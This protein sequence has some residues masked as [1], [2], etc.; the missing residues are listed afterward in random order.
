MFRN[1]SILLI[2]IICFF[3]CGK[4]QQNKEKKKEISF[5]P[6]VTSKGVNPIV[7]LSINCPPPP[8]F[9][10]PEKDSNIKSGQP[11]ENSKRA[12]IPPPIT[13]PILSEEAGGLPFIQTF[14]TE[15]GLGLSTISCGN[16]DHNGNLWFGTQ[17]GGVSKYD[18]KSFTNYTTAQGL[19][20]NI[21][22]CILEDKMGNLWFGTNGGGVSRYDGKSFTSYTTEHGLA[23]NIVLSIT[24]DNNGSLW[25]STT[26]GISKQ[27][28]TIKEKSNSSSPPEERVHFT[29][30]TI[31]QGL[32]GNSVLTSLADTKGNIWFGTDKG[33][34]KFNPNINEKTG[35][36]CFSNFTTAQGLSNNHVLDI[37]EDKSGN[38]WFGT[39][40]GGVSKYNP[41]SK[42]RPGDSAFLNYSFVHDN[43]LNYVYCITEDHIGNLWFGTASGVCKYDPTISHEKGALPMTYFNTAQGLPNEGIRSITE[44]NNG[45]I[46]FGTAGGGLAKYEG[47]AFTSF[48]KD[49]GLAVSMIWS[50]TEDKSNNLW[51]IGGSGI[52]KYERKSV[53]SG[54]AGITNVFI[55]SFMTNLRC[56]IEDK[57]GNIWLGGGLGLAKY[58]GKSFTFFNTSQG[59]TF[60]SILSI[61][62]DKTGNLWLGTYGGGVSKYDGNRIDAIEN[63][64]N[65]YSQNQQD[66][67]KINGKFVKSFTN[68]TTAQGLAG[69]VVKCMLE[70]KRG[71]MWFGTNG[72]G[73]SKYSCPDK[74]GNSTFTNYSLAQGLSNNVV[75]SIKEDKTGNIW[76]G[77]AGGGVCKWEPKQ[78]GTSSQF[79]TYNSAQGL[80]NDMVYAMVEDTINNTLWVG[81]N[82]GLSALKLNSLSS[83]EP[84]PKFE[85]FNKSTGYPIKDINTS[86]LVLDKKGILW[87]GTSEK[88]VRFDYSSIRKSAEPPKV[89][90]QA[91]KIQEE[92]IGWY[93]LK[94]K[95]SS[96][97]ENNS[98]DSLA[99][100]NEEF[101]TFGRLLTDAQRDAMCKRFGDIKFSSITRFYPLPE[102]LI[103]PFEHNNVTFDF[104]AIETGRPQMIRYQYILEGYDN[105]WS[106]VS[107]KTTASFGN[108]HEG[109][110]TF[111]LKAQSPDGIWSKP[112]NYTFKVLPPW[113]RTWWMYLSYLTIG[114]LFIGS[115]IKWRERNLKHEKLI[116]EEKVELRTKQLE[117]KNKIVEEQK[118]VVE[119]RNTVIT[120]SIE[121]A[122]NIQQAILPSEEEIDK[123]FKNHFILYKPKDIVSGDFYWI[124]EDK[125]RV[126][127]AVADCTGHGVSG[128][129]M[130]LLGNDFLNNIIKANKKNTPSEILDELNIQNCLSALDMLSFIVL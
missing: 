56:V 123:Q 96:G 88:L 49:Q 25:F 100:L 78:E 45:N 120:D 86:A 83:D 18:G 77:T 47:K 2:V 52:S 40:G 97:S 58:D 48:T 46:W 44:D 73:I 30:Y 93:Y 114:L 130:S 81:T 87:A 59:L 9:L 19:P 20:N 60:K 124:Y 119:E 62:E 51:F 84:T 39:L 74:N 41:T 113:Y 8:V 125:E 116:L 4:E 75:Y 91:V 24:E 10:V 107:N 109:N 31:A 54:Q 89:F 27:E 6:P 55:G 32:I 22:K 69:N 121:Y 104:I 76:F 37:T 26:G 36:K 118:K 115:F 17:G 82:L 64:E 127:F 12:R 7:I 105:E 112:I 71:N 85:N 15:Q 50:I 106:P 14:N 122:L 101:T 16:K 99:I 129:F 23:D 13:I 29:N 94:S 63:G 35:I 111:K 117:E 102:N 5:S 98:S 80:A 108:I 57:R 3:A 72:N 95:E 92:N 67:K 28:T 79:T 53:S 65:I 33:I 21:V 110:Y 11:Q 103:L 128:A 90:I 68:Y 38:I 61:A 34:S 70:D 43:P 1:S 42:E 66:L 126:F